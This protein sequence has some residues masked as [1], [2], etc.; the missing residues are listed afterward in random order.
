MLFVQ[1]KYVDYLEP[2]NL[3]A[4]YVIP[5]THYCVPCGRSVRPARFWRAHCWRYSSDRGVSQAHKPHK[6]EDCA[7]ELAGMVSNYC[8]VILARKKDTRIDRAS[9]VLA[10]WC[11]GTV[12]VVR[13]GGS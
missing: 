13:D 8:L 9:D 4:A 12:M 7:R 11:S 2:C 3:E 10:H 6:S 1:H 5:D